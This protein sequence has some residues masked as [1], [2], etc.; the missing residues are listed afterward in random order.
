MAAFF[1]PPCTRWCCRGTVYTHHSPPEGVGVAGEMAETVVVHG[2]VVLLRQVD[3]VRRED[4]TEEPD[5][6]RRY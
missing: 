6:Q 2:G 3:E 1:A 4:E 5:V